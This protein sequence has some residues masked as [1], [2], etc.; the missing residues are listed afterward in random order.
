M[1]SEV[2]RLKTRDENSRQ[3]VWLLTQEEGKE[4]VLLAVRIFF[5][6]RGDMFMEGDFDMF[7]PCDRQ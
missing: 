4:T 2:E 7:P 1:P 5:R 3:D 6:A